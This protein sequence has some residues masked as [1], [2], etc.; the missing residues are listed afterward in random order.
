MT[1]VELVEKKLAFIATCVRELRQLSQPER[2][3]HD[4]REER[5]V[6]HTLQIAIQA[7]LDIAS[8][9]VSDERLGEPRTN[10]ELFDLLRQ[11]G[12]LLPALADT[13]RQMV[14][15]RN[16]VVHGYAN[17]DSRIMRDIVENRLDDLLAFAAAIST[18]LEP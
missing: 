1:D 12:W 7:V 14:G 18:R 16:I 8:H 5:F 13:M 11:H 10:G 9:I 6:A 15:F 17:V 4:I 2:I 3:E